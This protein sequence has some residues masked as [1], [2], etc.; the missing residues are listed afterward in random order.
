MNLEL[1]LDQ[2][3]TNHEQN[4]G[5]PMVSFSNGLTYLN[6][7]P[8]HPLSLYA[9]VLG[10]TSTVLLECTPESSS[11]IALNGSTGS[12]ETSWIFAC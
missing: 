8:D 4:V 9:V 6:N 12:P 5:Q 11:C 2:M 10:E 1:V 3:N 7:L